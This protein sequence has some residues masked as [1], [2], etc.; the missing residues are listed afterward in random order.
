[1]R[2]E[3]QGEWLISLVVSRYCSLQKNLKFHIPHSVQLGILLDYNTYVEIYKFTTRDSIRVFQ[4]LMLEM[5]KIYGWYKA[6]SVHTKS[7]D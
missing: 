6:P 7:M 3:I 1:M 4:L 2:A 5:A